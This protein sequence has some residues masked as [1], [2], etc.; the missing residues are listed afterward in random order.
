MLDLILIACLSLGENSYC[1]THG[2]SGLYAD[3]QQCQINAALIA[4]SAQNKLTNKVEKSFSRTLN[5]RVYLKAD[6]YAFGYTFT[7]AAN[8]GE[9]EWVAMGDAKAI[10][11][12][13]SDAFLDS[14]SDN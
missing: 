3:V 8:D 7:C 12:Y 11:Y 1:E 10:A 4:G 9:G 2:V 13:T 14:S 6:A 5:E